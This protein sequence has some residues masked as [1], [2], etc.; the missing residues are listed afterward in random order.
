ME[1]KLQDYILLVV[2][3]L[4]M[5]AADVVPGVSGGTIAFVTGI[6][7]ELI[8]SIKA[9]NIEAVKLL[10]TKGPLAFFKHINGMFLVS[11]GMGIAIS[12]ITLAKAMQELM[13]VAPI[14]LWS[15]FFGLI[16]GSAITI[17]PKIKKWNLINVLAAIAGTIIA[18]FI[19]SMTP[20]S[21]P[22]YFW[23]II[24]CGSIAICAMILPG[25][26][27]AFILLMFGKYEF[28]LNAI[29]SMRFDI[30]LLFGVGAAAGL[31]SF[32]NVFSWL[33]KKYHDTTTAILMGFMIGALN[34]VWPWKQTI[35]TFID[36]HGV[37]KPMLQQNI[38][39]SHFSELAG[40]DSQLGLAIVMLLVGLAVIIG[41]ERVV[42]E[43]K[44]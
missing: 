40:S 32:A 5:G 12:V 35:T 39:P 13:V 22:E 25:I 7:E 1:R 44:Q 19:T 4:A 31:V 6:Y 26:S 23:F 8:N 43:P 21:T 41:F 29:S 36:R 28:I 11:V 38:L 9:V 10:F 17:A 27:G 20:A 16:I 42:R 37:E 33:L 30:I 24:L 15:F 14:L 3:G 18:Y 34:K 2:R